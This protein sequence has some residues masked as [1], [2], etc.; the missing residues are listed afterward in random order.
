MGKRGPKPQGG[1]WKGRELLWAGRY[2]AVRWPGHSEARAGVAPIHRVIAS[3]RLGRP[4]HRGEVVK[5][6]DG[7]YGN[8]N[9]SNLRIVKKGS[10]LKPAAKKRK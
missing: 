2:P 10:W 9:D 8:W 4:L 1:S 5:H 7:N 3:E 6:R